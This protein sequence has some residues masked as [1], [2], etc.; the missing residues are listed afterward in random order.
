MNTDGLCRKVSSSTAQWKHRRRNLKQS[1]MLKS[2]DV[3]RFIWICVKWRLSQPMSESIPDLNTCTNVVI[4]KTDNNAESATAHLT[5]TSFRGETVHSVFYTLQGHWTTP[6]EIFTVRTDCVQI[7]YWVDVLDT[8]TINKHN[9]LPYGSNLKL[10]THI[11]TL[12]L[13]QINL[14][15]VN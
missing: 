15:C 4:T 13:I 6:V 2:V 1:V 9:R 12:T 7:Q 10:I 3:N 5:L 14:L 11:S 8:D